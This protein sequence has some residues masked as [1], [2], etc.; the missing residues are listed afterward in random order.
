MEKV[1]YSFDKRGDLIN[2][3]NV[4]QLVWFCED[5]ADMRLVIINSGQY[6]DPTYHR[7]SNFWYWQEVYTD[8]SLGKEEHGYG[9]FYKY[10]GDYKVN[11]IISFQ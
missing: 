6:L 2:S 10:K 5:K 4:N 7:L 8:G 1:Q 3:P 11:R 9:H